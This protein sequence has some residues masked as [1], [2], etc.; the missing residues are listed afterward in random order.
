M[1]PELLGRL[2]RTVEPP[3]PN[4][5]RDQ[6]VLAALERAWPTVMA[7]EIANERVKCLTALC[8][9]LVSEVKAARE[10]I[11][12]EQQAKADELDSARWLAATD[13]DDRAWL[14]A[15]EYGIDLY[16]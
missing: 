16:D 8:E 6:Q 11:E 5:E 10:D 14:T 7:A 1:T 9:E 12:V 3:D 15:L 13:Q 2:A 4:R